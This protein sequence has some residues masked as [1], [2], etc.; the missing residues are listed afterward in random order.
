[1]FGRDSESDS[2]SESDSDSEN[3]NYATSAIQFLQSTQPY[4]NLHNYT[5]KQQLTVC[6]TVR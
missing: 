4:T 5:D 2:G 3:L 6:Q 1:M